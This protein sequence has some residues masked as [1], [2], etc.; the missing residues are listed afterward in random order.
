M[1][2]TRTREESNVGTSSGGRTGRGGAVGPANAQDAYVIGV[3]GALT[4]PAA[5]TNGPPI[6]GLRLY[7]DRLNAAGGINGKKIQADRARRSRRAIES[8][9]QRQ[10]AAHAGERQPA[11]AFAASPRPIA[12]VIAETRR[13]NVAAAC[14]DGRGLPEG[15][16]SA[17]RSA[18]VLHHRLRRRLRQPRDARLHQGDGEGAG[19]DRP[20]GD[21][22]PALARRDRLRR[23]AVARRSA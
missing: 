8:G 23:G 20:G 11:G 16:L 14:F 22:D 9:G 18:A 2:A 17:G 15:G 21:G 5:G 10:A 13:A 19:A 4:G 6:E 3:T 1:N 12:P 7:V